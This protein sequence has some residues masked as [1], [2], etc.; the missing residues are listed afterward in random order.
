MSVDKDP[1]KACI[2]MN[3]SKTE[4]NRPEELTTV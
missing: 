4:W 1:E 3:Y 2:C